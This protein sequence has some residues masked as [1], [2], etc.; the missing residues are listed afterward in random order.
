M[1]A[2]FVGPRSSTPKLSNGQQNHN[3]TLPKVPKGQ[4]AESKKPK[5]HGRVLP[6]VPI[7]PSHEGPKPSRSLPRVPGPIMVKSPPGTSGS[8]SSNKS[9]NSNPAIPTIPK[10][11]RQLP[12]IPKANTVQSK[13]QEQDRKKYMHSIYRSEGDDHLRK[14]ELEKALESYHG[15][16][17]LIPDDKSTLVARSRCHQLLGRHR[18]A[19][20]DVESA[21]NLDPLFYEALYQKAELHYQQR[22]YEMA[23]VFYSK[24]SK[25]RPDM[26]AFQEGL[27]KT[28]D[29][30]NRSDSARTRRL[31]KAGEMSFF[32]PKKKKE[33]KRRANLI[34]EPPEKNPREAVTP[35]FRLRQ[36][37][38]L[39]KIERGSRESLVTD[40]VSDEVMT[41]ENDVTEKRMKQIL[42]RMYNDKKYLEQLVEQAGGLSVGSVDLH[43]MAEN[44][45]DFLYDR[46][47]YWVRQGR[48]IPPEAPSNPAEKSSNH[49]NQS[50][51]PGLT[52]PRSDSS[53]RTNPKPKLS[54]KHLLMNEDKTQP[55]SWFRYLERKKAS[56]LTARKN[57]QT[58]FLHVLE[59][60]RLQL[61]ENLENRK[62]LTPIKQTKPQIKEKKVKKTGRKSKDSHKD[63]NASD[64]DSG[65][66]ISF[67]TYRQPSDLHQ[68]H[69]LEDTSTFYPIKEESPLPL[70]VVPLH[71]SRLQSLHKKD[72]SSQEAAKREQIQIYIA[73]E[74]EEIEIAYVDGRYADCIS[75]AE[76]C[77]NTLKSFTE[78][79]VP[80]ITSIVA[81]LHSYIGNA[82][83]ETKD[84]LTAL[85]HH[86]RDLII[87]EENNDDDAVSRALGNL[88]RIFVFQNKH[89][90]ALELFSRKVPL[91]KTRLETAWLYHEIGNCFLVLGQYKFAMEAAHRSL[92]AAEEAVEW[93][94]QLQSLVLLGVAEVKLKSYSSAISTFERAREHAR[95]QGD[96]KAEEAVTE[97]IKDVNTKI[98]EE[99]KTSRGDHSRSE[100]GFP[101]SR[102]DFSDKMSY[103]PRSRAEWSDYSSIFIPDDD[104][105]VSLT[106]TGYDT[107]NLHLDLDQLRGDFETSLFGSQAYLRT[108]RYST[109]I[110]SS[111]VRQSMTNLHLMQSPGRGP[112]PSSSTYIRSNTAMG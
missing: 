91:C 15:A 96:V 4:P 57:N 54:R 10:T 48:I 56:E 5:H 2:S 47:L 9:N 62:P 53:T 26:K 46:V 22:E 74:L 87:G 32:L 12:K 88:G 85:E 7:L 90:Q 81:K 67:S 94:Y 69:S 99:M 59:G 13:R 79:Q 101:R 80:N 19:M 61:K 30:I 109:K 73:K 108:E 49:D 82:A 39:V 110:P 71:N 20:Q 104:G 100:R 8:G 64:T 72:R 97:A 35:G 38:P 95:M 103:N 17:K 34:P 45:L 11:T 55:K 78:I 16:L 63:H 40:G 42:G 93:S 33:A 76:S 51:L 60:Q 68:D 27:E 70:K 92:K 66:N 18:K 24:G 1:T 112:N 41:N 52:S 3:R 37:N 75:Q 25:Q 43:S 98:I 58:R 44:G 106:E 102:A 111:D 89:Q 21:L 65:L 31:A 83:I 77:L 50:M 84:Y 29:A 105:D 36:H 14:G 6:L 86:E 107:D 28:Q 23:L